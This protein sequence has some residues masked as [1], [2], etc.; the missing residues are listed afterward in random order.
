MAEAGEYTH[1]NE[2]GETQESVG[3]MPFLLEGD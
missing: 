1:P 3:R 2:I